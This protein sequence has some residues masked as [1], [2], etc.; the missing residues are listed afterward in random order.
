MGRTSAHASS[1]LAGAIAISLGLY[2]TVGLCLGGGFYWLMQ[3]KVIHNVG[4]AAYQPPPRTVLGYA[5]ARVDYP[6]PTVVEGPVAAAPQQTEPVVAR[7]SESQPTPPKRDTGKG[8]G[9][10]STRARRPAPQRR[11]P[12]RDFAYQ[13]SFGFRPW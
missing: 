2:L 6:A 9:A 4:V 8:Q 1:G 3:P 13:P 5:P 7:V 12:M 10:A 11:D